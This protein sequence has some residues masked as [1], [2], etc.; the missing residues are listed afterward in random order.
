MSRTLTT[1]KQQLL[2]GA[3]YAAHTRFWCGPPGG[4]LLDLSDYFLTGVYEQG[5]DELIDALTVN[6]DRSMGASS[7]SPLMTANPPVDLGYDIVFEAAVTPNATAVVSGDWMELFRGSVRAVDPTNERMV[8]VCQDQGGKLHQRKI[9]V[10]RQYGAEPPAELDTVIQAILTDNATGETVYSYQPSGAGVTPYSQKLESVLQATRTLAETIGDTTRYWWDD[11]TS[12]FRFTRLRPPR[13]KVDPDWTMSPSRYLQVRELK[14]DLEDVRNDITVEFG[15]ANN[16]Q[17]V[18]VRDEDSIA[19][20]GEIPM[21]IS[22][23]STSPVQTLEQ[24]TALAN[25]ALSDLSQPDVTHSVEDFFQPHLQIWDLLNFLPNAVHYSTSQQLAIMSLRH[26]FLGPG[27]AHTT[28]YCRGKPSAGVLMWRRR[29]KAGAQDDLAQRTLPPVTTHSWAA[30]GKGRDLRLTVDPEEATIFYRLH[31]SGPWLSAPG[32]SVNVPITFP[33]NE[34]DPY[35]ILEFYGVLPNGLAEKR[36]QI[37]LDPDSDPEFTDCSVT[38]PTP[39]RILAKIVGMDDDVSRWAIYGRRGAWPWILD[40][41]GNPTADPDPKY[42]KDEGTRLREEAETSWHAIDG[43]WYVVFR[44]FDEHGRWT[45]KTGTLTVPSNAPPA[46]ALSSLGVE[47]VGGSHRV[48]WNHNAA[49]AGTNYKVAIR[50]TVS[51]VTSDVLTL[52]SARPPTWDPG[53]VVDTLPDGGG[54]DVPVAVGGGLTRHFDYDVILYDGSTFIASYRVGIDGNNYATPVTKPASGPGNVRALA[55]F[56]S[57][58]DAAWENSSTVWMIEIEY[59]RR[60]GAQW[61]TDRLIQIPAGSS[62]YY[63]GGF[64]AG[65]SYRVFV[66]YVN[67]AGAGPWSNASNTVTVV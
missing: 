2:Q 25:A 36:R 37:Q 8:V 61:T 49:A 45:Q 14:K 55:T 42:L 9:K 28:A 67:S 27:I 20:Y 58:I 17:S 43:D 39:N 53:E 23:A 57:V 22:E 51:G 13:D 52:G 12:Q 5:T 30:H 48:T 10:I 29:A 63:T 66:R 59:Q 33:V 21:R 1:A 18:N 35:V 38:D 50:E 15:P 47:L 4:A 40:V 16:R 7:L 62:S 3:H 31:L 34:E 6:L 11:A 44:V 41:N 32:P 26:E 56:A 24:A 60:V 46:G 19:A 65:Q 64:I 54:Y